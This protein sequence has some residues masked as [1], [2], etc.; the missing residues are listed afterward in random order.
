MSKGHTICA[1]YESPQFAGS[2]KDVKWRDIKVGQVLE[3]RDNEDF[4]ADLLCLSCKR[5]DG[6]AYIRTTNLD[7]IPPLCFLTPFALVTLCLKLALL[8]SGSC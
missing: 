4:P 3:V 5:S 2:V 6:V 1:L 7:G 8:F